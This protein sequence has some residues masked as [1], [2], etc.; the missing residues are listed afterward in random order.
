MD[1][2]IGVD[3]LDSG[4]KGHAALG[5][6]TAQGGSAQAQNRAQTLAPGLQA[7]Q[8]GILEPL[9]HIAAVKT[10][11]QIGFHILAPRVQQGLHVS[12][13]HHRLFRLL[14]CV[15]PACRHRA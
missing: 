14:F 2:R 1:E 6:K 9:R 11:G 13:A 10:G 4:S 15:Q 3:H 5:R 7:V 8:H 12:N